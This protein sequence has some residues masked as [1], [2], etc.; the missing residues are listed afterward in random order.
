MIPFAAAALALITLDALLVFREDL[1]VR[2]VLLILSIGVAALLALASFAERAEAD[3]PETTRAF[4]LYFAA[5]SGLWAAGAAFFL[6]PRCLDLFPARLFC[7]PRVAAG[8]AT[9]LG[10]IF[11]GL[12]EGDWEFVRTN[13]FFVVHLGVSASAMAFGLLVMVAFLLFGGRRMREGPPQA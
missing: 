11:R 9:L 8:I 10:V 13:W 2:R 7:G 12:A 1:R 6:L 5:A 3:Q 4:F